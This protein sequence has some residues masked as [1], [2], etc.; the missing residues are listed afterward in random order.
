LSMLKTGRV[1][2]YASRPWPRFAPRS[3][4]N[5]ATF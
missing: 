4:A 3:I 2:A 5:P 1:R